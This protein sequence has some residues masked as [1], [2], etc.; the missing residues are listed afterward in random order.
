MFHNQGEL[1][2]DR[3]LFKLILLLPKRKMD[4]SVSRSDGGLGINKISQ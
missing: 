3:E 4:S 2:V 1:G